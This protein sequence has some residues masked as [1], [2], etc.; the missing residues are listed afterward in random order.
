VRINRIL[1]SVK[2]A[3]RLIIK[4]FI[5][6]LFFCFIH[7][8][9]S[10]QSSDSSHPLLFV[11]N[12]DHFPSNDHFVFS[13]IQIPWTRD[14][15]YTVNHDSLRIRINNKGVDALII[16]NLVLSSDSSWKID[17]ING[18]TYTPNSSLPVY[19]ASGTYKDIVVKFIAVDQATRVKVLHD[20]LTIFSNDNNTPSKTV[21]L[22]GLLQKQGEGLNEPS[23][24]EVINAFGLKTSTGFGQTDPDKGDS[25]RLKGDEILPSYF[26]RADSSIPVS[27][28]QIAAYHGCCNTAPEKIIWYAKDTTTTLHTLFTHVLVDGQT[29]LPR[30]SKPNT[31]AEGTFSPTSAFGFKVGSRNWTDPKLNPAGKIGIRVW[32]AIDANGSII[33]NSYILSNDY[34]GTEF[35]NYDFQDNMYF[36]KN[37]KPEIGSAFFSTLSSAPSDIDFGEKILKT[38]GSYQLKL[39]NTGKMYADSSSDPVINISSIAITGE[40]SSEFSA[41]MPVKAALG[42]LDSTTLNVIFKPVTQGLKIADLLIYYSNS[43]SPLR[44]PLYGIARSS[45]TIVRV[46]YRISSGS[47]N[48]I[49]VNGKTWGADNQYAYDNLEPYTNPKLTQIAGTDE[50]ALYLK[51]QSSNG[52]K[53]PFRY[54][55]PIENGNYVVRLHFAEI[56]WGAPGSGLNGGTGSRVMNVSLENQPRL[57]N[58]DVTREVGGATALIKNVPVTVADGRLNIDF[59]SN[60]NRA[61]VVAVEIYS[62]FHDPTI[63]L[64][65]A[66]PTVFVFPEVNTLKRPKVYPNPLQKRFKIEFPGDYSGYS[67]LQ[68]IDAAGRT[69]E[70]GTIRLQ[71][72]RSNITEVDISKLSLKAGFYYLKIVSDTRP[73]DV[74]KLIIK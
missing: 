42:P 52:D 60:V 70:I 24:Q 65:S 38:A 7:I 63:V 34:L 39:F 18:I 36:V 12:P 41:S 19:I 43:L 22:S 72:G 26:V 35:T 21:F 11:E 1:C 10:A 55:F 48:P 47:S 20:S 15:I 5:A 56:Y 4:P 23:A 51:E 8:A 28:I 31:P 61:M 32:K 44:V 69:Y 74:I 40:D 68:L 9:V 16:N 45:D 71:R 25:S 27:V 2:Q 3:L 29:L 13:R 53:K 64:S 62:F 58:F 66:D 57:I 6:G 49:I 14:S 54:E 59:T 30:K 50:D 46:N 37:I 17:N 67:S 73:I 33:P